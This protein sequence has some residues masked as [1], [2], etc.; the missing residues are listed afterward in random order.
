MLAWGRSSVG[1]YS[2]T[3]RERHANRDARARDPNRGD[4]LLTCFLASRFACHSRRRPC[5]QANKKLACFW[6]KKKSRLKL[7][8]VM[9]TLATRSPHFLRVST[10]CATG[11]VQRAWL[12]YGSTIIWA[13][14]ERFT[15]CASK[16]FLSAENGD[17][18]GVTKSCFHISGER[19]DW[20]KLLR[21]TCKYI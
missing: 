18:T 11:G 6:A 1:G 4:R 21:N 2:R 10:A 5:S 9:Y 3:T 20:Q 12:L 7:L 14:P 8:Q 17:V 15:S 13:C 16:S 19:V